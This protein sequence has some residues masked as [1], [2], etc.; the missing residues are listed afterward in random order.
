MLAFG[1][2]SSD[3]RKWARTFGEGTGRAIFGGLCDLQVRIYHLQAVL[4]DPQ[5]KHK[6][7]RVD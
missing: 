6:V 7:F 5:G 1:W 2:D 3:R 4:W